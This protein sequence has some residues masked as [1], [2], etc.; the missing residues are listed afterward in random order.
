[1]QPAAGEL[2]DVLRALAWQ[3]P[4]L[5]SFFSQR[6][7]AQRAPDD[8]QLS[9]D[10][11]AALMHDAQ[12]GPAKRQKSACESLVT[13][14]AYPPQEDVSEDAPSTTPARGPSPSRLPAEP[15]DTVHKS[16]ELLRQGGSPC[17]DH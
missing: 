8:K 17:E 2:D 6:T 16:E 1:M 10:E 3:S 4:V 13:C 7:E 11:M 12:H 5:S 14:R 15:A 9:L